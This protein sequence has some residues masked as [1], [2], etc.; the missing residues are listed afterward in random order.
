M[1]DDFRDMT[2]GELIDNEDAFKALVLWVAANA[3]VLRAG[4]DWIEG[5]AS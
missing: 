4:L 3:D 5:L 2:L 1:S